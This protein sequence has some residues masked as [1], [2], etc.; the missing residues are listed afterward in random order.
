LIDESKSSVRSNFGDKDEQGLLA[1]RSLAAL[2]C[3]RWLGGRQSVMNMI[4]SQRKQ[5]EGTAATF[6]PTMSKAKQ[7]LVKDDDEEEQRRFETR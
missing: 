5:W 7:Q 3:I 1:V 4:S 6:G 2:L